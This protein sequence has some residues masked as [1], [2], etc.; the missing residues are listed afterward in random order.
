MK[1]NIPAIVRLMAKQQMNN[2][3]L[4][5]QSGISR[6]SISTILRRGTCS[7]TNLGRIAVA[8][9]VEVDE[10]WKED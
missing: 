9:G 6:Q 3:K 7:V 1:L 8:L 2:V 5:E 4:S 10:I